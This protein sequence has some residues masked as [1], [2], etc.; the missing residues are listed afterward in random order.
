M[1][2]VNQAELAELFD[3]TPKTIREW[4][5][6]GMPDRG[7]KGRSVIYDTGECFHW[8]IEFE[9][10][11]TKERFGVNEEASEK[12]NL[13]EAKT[14]KESANALLAELELA[15]ALSQV[16]NIDDLMRN[17]A[18]ALQSVRAKLIG[19]SNRLSGNL[20]HQDQDE[21]CRILDE[22]ADETLKALS[23]FNHKYV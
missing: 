4:R 6:Q 14:R 15:K 3:V 16:A 11:R 13:L 1:S 19:Q 23:D 10:A 7:K 12:M 5:E 8:R 9:A 18:T 21:V 22:D 2:E 20:A 17:V